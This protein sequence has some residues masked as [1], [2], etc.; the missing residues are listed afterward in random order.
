MKTFAKGLAFPEGPIALADGSVLVV[1]VRGETLTRCLPDGSRTV[2]AE[3]GG[4]PNG[5]AIGKDGCCYICNNGGF[6]WAPHGGIIRPSGVPDSYTGGWIEKVNLGTGEITRL[7]E[8]FGDERLRGP[9]DIVVDA[10]G[11]LWFTDMGKRRPRSVDLGSV[12]FAKPDGSMI[13]EVI[14]PLLTPNGISLS[15]DGKTLYVVETDAARIWA[16][17][18]ESPGELGR[19][20]FPSPHGGRMVMHRPSTQI[21]LDD[22]G[23]QRQPLHRE[24]HGG[25]H[26]RNLAPRRTDRV[27]QDCT[28]L[29]RNQHLLWRFGHEEGIHH[30]LGAR[31]NT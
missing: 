23:S 8:G 6:S 27:C 28:G 9:N 4:G 1:E 19:Q 22:C 2:V 5:A 3:L 18:I 12:C 26:L 24:L 17:D 21:R 25:R 13:R 31:A 15:P 30:P 16:W 11:N 14:S 10:H 29:V 20:P 7:Y